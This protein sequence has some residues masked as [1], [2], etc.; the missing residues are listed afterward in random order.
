MSDPTD[1][2]NARHEE[3]VAQQKQ[4]D[5]KNLADAVVALGIGNHWNFGDMPIRYRFVDTDE[6]M[7]ASDF[8]RDWRVAGALMEKCWDDHS[9]KIKLAI[10]YC[11]QINP[12]TII[13]VCVEARGSVEDT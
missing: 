1:S 3:D 6:N 7:Y 11:Q 9:A 10:G 4:F 2:Y 12:R 5:D 13:E 8:V